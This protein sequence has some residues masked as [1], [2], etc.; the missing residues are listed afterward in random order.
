[1]FEQII[2]EINNHHKIIIIRHQN[3]D[4]DAIGSQLGLATVLRNKFPDKK[5]YTPGTEL[6][7]FDWLGKM[8]SITDSA[9]KGALII[10]VDTANKIR[11][12]VEHHFTDQEQIIKIDH[13]PNDDPFGKIN[14]V[15]ENFSSCAEMIFTFAEKTDLPVNAD[16]ARLL[17]AGLIGD[18]NRF[19]YPETNAQTLEIAAKLVKTGINVSEISQHE[20]SMSLEISRLEAYI[21]EN[22]TLTEN[23]FGYIVI[24][25]RN[26][27]I[28]N[29]NPGEL[30][31]AVPLI[32]KINSVKTWAVISEPEPEKFRVNLRSKAV[33]INQI[34]VKYGG[35]G[36]P[37]ASGVFLHDYKSVDHLI[38]DMDQI[39]KSTV[40]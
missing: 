9:Y 24:D 8:Q 37:L 2:Q 18:T 29:L 25:H 16:A 35:G 30:D 27:R 38:E 3:P 15:D 23:G 19:L 33:S 34:A 4:P 40:E 13:H 32:G 1:M 31:Y 14:W 22:F 11:I 20:D 5:I 26:L 12:D 7:V 10:A 39:T 6:E 17:Y 21:L 36:H 28:F